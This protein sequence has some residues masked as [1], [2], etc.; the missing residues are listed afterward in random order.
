[1]Q[2]IDLATCSLEKLRLITPFWSNSTITEA[3][4]K[5][6][7]TWKAFAEK[8]DQPMMLELLRKEAIIRNEL[9][10][11]MKKA[12]WKNHQTHWQEEKLIGHNPHEQP[13]RIRTL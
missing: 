7:A 10:V 2:K 5:I 9:R 13:L 8:Y 1:M 12:G 6:R 3:L 11:R 4:R